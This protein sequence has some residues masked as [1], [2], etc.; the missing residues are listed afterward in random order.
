MIITR[1]PYRVSFFGGGSDYPAWYESHG[2]AVLSATIARYC[3]IAVRPVPELLGSN[4]SL[5]Y[6][7]TEHV[8]TAEELKHH[9]ARGCLS[10]LGIENGFEISHMGDLPARSGL[11]SSSAFTVGLLHALHAERG[12]FIGKSDLARQAIFVERDV[13]KETVGIQDQIACAHGGLNL[14]EF[15]KSGTHVVTPLRLPDEL[16]T[17]LSDR[18]MLV[19]TGRQ[20]FASE[21]ASAQ[22]SNVSNKEREL[23]EIV[24]LAYQAA[25]LLTAGDL[26]GF[27]SLLHETWLLKRGLSDKVSDPELDGIYAKA[28]DAGALGGKILG[29]GGGGFFLFYVNDKTAVREAL[30]LP[31]IPVTFDWDGSQAATV[32]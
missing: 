6:A 24:A 25:T 7:Q 13:L 5:L 3:W 31:D 28:R 19:Y 4:L 10:H 15:D 27:G 14:I 9:S 20:R 29:A 22:V 1:T 17:A 18:L 30:G 21:I 12:D 11:G 2:G 32:A 26:D 16:S 8:D 23:N